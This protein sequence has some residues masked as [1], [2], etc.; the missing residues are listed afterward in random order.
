MEYLEYG[1][2]GSAIAF[3]TCNQRGQARIAEGRRRR[4]QTK[5]EEWASQVGG[6]RCFAFYFRRREQHWVFFGWAP[7][8]FLLLSNAQFPF[9]ASLLATRAS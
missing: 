5:S 7:L 1:C 4:R 3:R 2:S 8:A 9:L 6:G